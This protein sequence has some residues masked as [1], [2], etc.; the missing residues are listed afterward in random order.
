ML[1]EVSA[2][3]EMPSAGVAIGTAR[4]TRNTVHPPICATRSRPERPERSS[5]A[6][7]R[8]L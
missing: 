5:S 4:G 1:V 7:R 2:S 3:T 6:S 8:A